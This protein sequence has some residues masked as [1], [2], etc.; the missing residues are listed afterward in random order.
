MSRVN[1]EDYLLEGEKILWKRSMINPKNKKNIRG[2]YLLA[3][4]SLLL[5]IPI[6]IGFIMGVNFAFGM[7]I[8]FLLTFLSVILGL[9]SLGLYLTY[10]RLMKALQLSFKQIKMYEDTYILTNK[11]W[12]QQWLDVLSF[13]EGTFP[14]DAKIHKDI[15]FIE[16]NKI[17]SFA[18]KR[19][20]SFSGYVIALDVKF[21]HGPEMFIPYEI[22]PEFIKKLSELINIKNEV[23]K[24]RGVVYYYLE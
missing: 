10:Y 17:K 23:H 24:K 15:I 1:I 13:N 22:F 6:I 7:V 8:G 12:I 11:R 2:I 14:L 18:T 19:R 5:L 16:L 9:V 21:P 3:S 20:D 4:L